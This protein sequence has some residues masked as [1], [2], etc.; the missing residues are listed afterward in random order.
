[1]QERYE[2]IEK[3]L[4]VMGEILFPVILL[5]FPLLKVNQGVDLT[6]TPYSLGNYRF[7]A[8]AE[9]VWVLSTFLSNVA[10]FVLTKLPM[11][12]TMLGM[13]IYTSLLISAMALLSYRFFKT[14]M[15]SWMAFLGEVAA[16]G[17]C[18]CPTGILYNYM[19]Y[20][21]FL[22]GAIFLF[23]GL[24][25]S[26]PV[27]LVIAGVCLGLNVAVRVPNVLEVSLIVALW[28]YGALKKKNFEQIAK[29]TGLCV[30]G[31]LAAQAIMF[32]V[33]SALYGIGAYGEMIA[34]LFGMA[35]SASDY[36][37]GEM[38]LSIWS[39]YLRG[40]K[41]M[42]YM[43]LC[44]LPGIPFFMIQK[45]K[46]PLLRKIIYCACIAFLFYVL[47]R[48]GMYNFRYYQKE[49]ALQWGVIFL[50]ITIVL[51]IWTLFTKMM[52]DEWK[53]I[54]CMV[55]VVVLVTPLG[56]NNYVWPALNNL[57]LVAPV[58]FWLLYRFVLWGRE[59]LDATEK[60][61]LFP[62][63]AMVG[64]IMIAF[65][66]QSIGIGFG[67]VFKDG[68]N[69]EERS[70]K[71]ENNAVLA[72]MYTTP[73]NAETLDEI[74]IFMTEHETEYVGKELILYGDICGLSY[75]L[76]KAPAI[77][78]SWPD[79]DTNS[80]ERLTADL[81]DISGEISEKGK[82][83]LVI[84][85]PQLDA[86]YRQDAEAMQWWG[87]DEDVC[88]VDEKLSAIMSFMDKNS[89]TQ[90]FANEAFVVYE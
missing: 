16:I 48:W 83:P 30:L 29:E 63:K 38:L 37:L 71:V 55:L 28:Y 69:G 86:F 70:V 32:A 58:T 57:F 19:T 65:L 14:K 73:L 59:Y 3:Y 46:F 34:G 82:R 40:F 2:K 52:D 75:Y 76:D 18:W 67:Y 8:Q 22:T 20:F 90:V 35:G 12:G 5:L 42:L 72:G 80:L 74:S 84:V 21:F 13:K 1:M 88:L 39:A 4:T 51:C 54:G 10:G 56:S 26:R 66:V 53:L 87:T 17:F 23:R 50:L 9:G 85:T 60:V 61:T 79:L 89:Y 44:I 25:G 68:E 41:W 15:P 43:I 47:G 62:V 45:E 77:F 31:F 24:A 81:E 27:C 78:T 33:M 11:G 64:G 6:D 7:F 36:T 49:S